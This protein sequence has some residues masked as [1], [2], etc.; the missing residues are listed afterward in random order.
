MT[1]YRSGWKTDGS[2]E[3]RAGSMQVD[4]KDI[5]QVASR[6]LG[7][8]DTMCCAASLD[9]KTIKHVLARYLGKEGRREPERD[10]K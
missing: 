3:P 8:G 9:A 10:E 7:P 5:L 6:G 4:R 2:A 1:V